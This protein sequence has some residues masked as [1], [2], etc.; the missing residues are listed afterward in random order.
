MVRAHSPTTRAASLHS[1]LRGRAA[2]LRALGSP[3]AR[4][5]NLHPHLHGRAALLRTLG[6]WETVRDLQAEIREARG[7][8]VRHYVLPACAAVDADDGAFNERAA[9][10]RRGW[11]DGISI[12]SSPSGSS[13]SD[14]GSSFSSIINGSSFSSGGKSAEAAAAA[15]AVVAAV[16]PALALCLEFRVQP[17]APPPCIGTSASALRACVCSVAERRRAIV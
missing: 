16:V 14:N 8:R 13:L 7:E 6:R 15:A 17:H 12:N 11:G 4:A 3:T 1:H 2:P 10:D 5:G 9:L